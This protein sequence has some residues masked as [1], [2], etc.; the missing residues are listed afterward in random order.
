MND[1]RQIFP[2]LFTMGNLFCGFAS[3]LSSARG[4]NPTEAAWLIILAA[5]F[6][7]LDGIV[8]RLSKGASQFGVELDSMA[9]VVSFGVAPAV[10]LISFEMVEFGRWDWVIGFAFVMTGVYRLAR[11]N[12]HADIETK[13]DFIGLPIPVA[14]CALASFVIFSQHIWGEIRLDRM[15][16]VMV[17]L[18]SA[19]MVSPI[20]YETVPLFD[21]TAKKYKIKILL[22]I[23]AVILVAF[24]TRLMMFPLI[25]LYVLSGIYRLIVTLF[26]KISEEKEK[27]NEV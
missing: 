16:A 4:G 18:T 19:L 8:A 22:L 5:F 25:A 2:G 1:L 15:L 10:M 20:R 7:Y 6:D 21:F 14:A 13:S 11:F 9:D 23:V 27:K 17:I 24:K 26:S 3:I 12:I